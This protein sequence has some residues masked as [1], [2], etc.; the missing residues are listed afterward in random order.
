MIGNSDIRCI[1]VFVGNRVGLID[2]V[3]GKCLIDFAG[4]L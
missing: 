3:E 2:D 4:C 1:L